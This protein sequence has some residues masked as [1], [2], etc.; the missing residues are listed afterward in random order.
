M[1][2]RL[3][4]SG[5]SI[6]ASVVIHPEFPALEP[7]SHKDASIFGR[8]LGGSFLNDDGVWYARPLS[9]LELLLCYSVDST[10]LINLQICLVMDSTL[11]ILSPGNI[12][13][14]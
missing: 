5:L 6:I 9:S 8:Q 3:D 13:F 14:I 11:D 12:P 4:P 7:G 2:A 1:V 10:L